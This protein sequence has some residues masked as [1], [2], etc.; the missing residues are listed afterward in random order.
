MKRWAIALGLLLTGVVGGVVAAVQA[1]PLVEQHLVR[2]I[3]ARLEQRADIKVTEIS[4]D[5]LKRRITLIEAAVWAHLDEEPV[6]AAER[7][8]VRGV[9]WPLAELLAGRTPFSGWKLGDPVN[10]ERIEALNLMVNEGQGVKWNAESAVI[11]GVELSRYRADQ[12][13]LGAHFLSA[14]K[15]RR[16]DAHNVTFESDTG[17][18]M[19]VFTTSVAVDNVNR[20]RIATVTFLDTGISDPAAEGDT[21]ALSVEEVT[22]SDI[23]LTPVLDNR[24]AGKATGR[25]LTKTISLSGF[26]G[27]LMKRYSVS[28]DRILVE[29]VRESADVTRTKARAEGLAVRPPEGIAGLAMRIAMMSIGLSEITASLECAG[30]EDRNKAE[31]EVGKCVLNSPGLAEASFTARIVDGDEAFWQALDGGN[32][33]TLA[34]SKAAL[35]SVELMVRDDSLLGRLVKLYADTSGQ[36]VAAARRQLAG[37][38]RRFAPTDVLITEDLGKILDAVARFVERGGTLTVTA[39]P[40]PALTF[41]RLLAL[42]GNGPDLVDLLGLKAVQSR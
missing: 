8:E 27:D 12:P 6:M 32:S 10:A 25:P 35:G 5:L 39:K 3:R 26:G 15:V 18:G 28:F 29:T 40:E 9:G 16:I 20:G 41:E 34:D 37:E 24:K 19:R 42:Q 30:R 11:E 36:E 31:L 21:P 4:I 17:E 7:V 23:D 38:I 22:L 2:Q 1:I 14:L 13:A 33:L